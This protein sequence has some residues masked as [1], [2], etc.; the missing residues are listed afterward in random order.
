[1]LKSI[2][3]ILICVII[4][5]LAVKI[6][7]PFVVTAYFQSMPNEDDRKI[8]PY[9]ICISN[10]RFIDAAKNEW[11]TAHNATNGDTVTANQLT[12][13]L[14]HAIMPE[15]PSGGIYKIGK[16]GQNPTCSLGT[17]VTPA[18]VLP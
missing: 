18:H 17:T 13:Y 7:T 12:N 14:P 4:G 1:M 11:A 10:L 8:Y 16:I 9:N 5:G 2:I 15:C 3:K 6:F